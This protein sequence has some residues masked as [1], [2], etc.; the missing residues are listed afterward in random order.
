MYG[1]N[2]RWYSYHDN[3][4][5]PEKGEGFITLNRREYKL[6]ILLK[7]Q[8]NNPKLDIILSNISASEEEINKI[9]KIL[10]ELR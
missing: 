6:L 2:G 5:Y 10:L 1:I 8:K 9:N 7:T 3:R 4:F